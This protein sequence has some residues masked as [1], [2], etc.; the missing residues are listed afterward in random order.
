MMPMT[1]SNGALDANGVVV[2]DDDDYDD[3]SIDASHGYEN[4]DTDDDLDVDGNSQEGPEYFRK[5]KSWI[6]N[7]FPGS[8]RKL[9][10]LNF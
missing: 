9:L 3:D 10:K 2:S 6:L 7:K 4:D 5:Q 8:P 1:W